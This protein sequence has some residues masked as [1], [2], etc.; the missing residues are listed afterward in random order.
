[1]SFAFFSL[2]LL[3]DGHHA[4]PLQPSAAACREAAPALRQTLK[5]SRRPQRR[6]ALLL[7]WRCSMTVPLEALHNDADPEVRLSAWRLT[8][9]G[10]SLDD[11]RWQRAL[12]GLPPPQ[13][14]SILAW[15][16]RLRASSQNPHLDRT[17]P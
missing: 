13:Q 8:L 17:A 7:L 2:A 3:V 11:P 1:M 6:R 5:E 12:E 16:Q 14:R 10:L 15:R 4:L 9:N